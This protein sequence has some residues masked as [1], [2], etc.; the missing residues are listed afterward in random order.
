MNISDEVSF[1][2]I[3]MGAGGM[4]IAG[5]GLS[6]VSSILLARYFGVSVFGEYSYLMAWV[7]IMIIVALFGQE[8]ALL[9]GVA[10]YCAE[11]K[12]IS[13]YNY[14]RTSDH[15]SVA[16]IGVMAVIAFI[17]ASYI[18]GDVDES[19]GLY[20]ILLTAFLS[21]TRVRQAVL[22]G[23]HRP[24]LAY[25]PDSLVYPLVIILIMVI[26]H[27]LDTNRW[28]LEELFAIVCISSFLSMMVADRMF[29]KTPNIYLPKENVLK[30]NEWL[31][32]CSPFLFLTVLTVM[33]QQINAIMIGSLTNVESVGVYVVSERLASL[34][35]LLM[36]VVNVVLA[37]RISLKFSMGNI[38]DVVTEIKSI[39][40]PL[41]ALSVLMFLG[42]IFLGEFVLSFYGVDFIS[43]YNALL[44]LGV[45]HIIN[46]GFGPVGYL[47]TMTG[48]EKKAIKA[49]LLSFVVNVCLN[50]LLIDDYGI[51][52]VAVSYAI[53]MLIWN[54]AMTV[55]VYKEFKV[56]VSAW[57]TIK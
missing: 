33:A 36:F 15:V 30:K 39:V 12:N 45:A 48:G 51:E 32:E 27:F 55:D 40:R 21:F 22:R 38:G 42:L 16:M 18:E 54:V 20:L 52:G 5:M 35:G 46:I 23:L 56:N 29:K 6:F 57:G 24:V 9:R 28:G 43:G 26:L 41:F 11:N 10:R 14:V 31:K 7:N 4:K 13:P 3:I 2:I 1:K 44:I 17:V 50:Y 25:I 47:L 19:I 34:L 37:P 49:L 8:N 53:S